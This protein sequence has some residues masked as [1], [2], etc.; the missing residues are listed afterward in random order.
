MSQSATSE[1]FDFPGV[2]IPVVSYWPWCSHVLSPC[3]LVSDAALPCSP[4]YL[5]SITPSPIVQSCCFEKTV[6]TSSFTSQSLTHS[7]TFTPTVPRKLFLL[8]ASMTPA[9]SSG[10]HDIMHLILVLQPT[11]LTFPS[12]SSLTPPLA[13]LFF[14]LSGH[15]YSSLYGLPTPSSAFLKDFNYCIFFY[16]FFLSKLIPTQSFSY[17]P[18]VNLNFQSNSDLL[19]ELQVNKISGISCHVCHKNLKLNTSRKWF[20]L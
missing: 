11:L 1:E 10:H 17:Y 7:P 16:T 2:G 14:S 13:S 4:H 15:S 9:K 3:C 12:F 6:S 8:W 5:E 18:W 19:S 20:L